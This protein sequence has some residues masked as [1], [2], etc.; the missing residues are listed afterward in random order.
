ML[1]IARTA[2]SP[3]KGVVNHIREM[4]W[5]AVAKLL[6]RQSPVRRMT[7]Q[8]DN[9]EPAGYAAISV[10]DAAAVIARVSG[11]RADVI[12]RFL[13]EKLAKQPAVLKMIA[14]KRSGHDLDL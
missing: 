11:K 2:A 6:T 4:I 7:D 1:M 14:A 3:V 8:K 10:K 5:M 9:P 12:E 13:E